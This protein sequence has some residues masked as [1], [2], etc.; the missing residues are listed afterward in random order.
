VDPRLVS[1]FWSGKRVLV[2]GHSGFKGSWL[3]LWL[4]SLGAEP[5]GFSAGVPTQPALFELSGMGSQMRSTE[6][7]VRD[8]DAVLEVVERER[9]EIVFHLAAQ[10][11]VRR[12]LASPALTY[13][14]NA[15]GTVNVLEGPVTNN[16]RMASRSSRTGLVPSALRRRNGTQLVHG[17]PVGSLAG[18]H[19][20]EG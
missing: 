5:V 3:C 7:D 13:Q 12:S 16:R 1:S 6:G 2:T 18:T 4:A 19:A 10:P 14:V 11:L 9:P 8:S 15:M 17:A 20:T